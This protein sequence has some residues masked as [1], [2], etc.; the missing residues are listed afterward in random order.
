MNRA[1]HNQR[2]V[3]HSCGAAIRYIRHSGGIPGYDGYWIH[4]S[5]ATTGCWPPQDD[6]DLITFA[7]PRI[8]RV[9][10]EYCDGRGEIM[11]GG[12]LCRCPKCDG[13]GVLNA[14]E[15]GWLD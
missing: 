14:K 10:C 7:S 5:P 13:N 8:E 15:L 6:P 12:D 9:E 3:C 4:V 1:E 11:Q 2:D